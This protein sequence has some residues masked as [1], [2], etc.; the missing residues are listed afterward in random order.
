[1]RKRT[2]RIS[3]P[4]KKVSKKTTSIDNV[5]GEGTVVVTSMAAWDHTGGGQTTQK[6]AEALRGFGYNILFTSCAPTPTPELDGIEVVFLP[7]TEVDIPKD[8][9]G[10]VGMAY[11]HNGADIMHKAQAAGIPFLYHALDW[12]EGFDNPVEW[13]SDIEEEMWQEADYVSASARVL[14]KHLNEA[15]GQRDDALYIANTGDSNYLKREWVERPSEVSVVYC[16]SAFGEWHDWRVLFDTSAMRPDWTISVVGPSPD[17]LVDE[18]RMHGINYHPTV[19]HAEL[20]HYIEA[21]SV[22][23]IPFEMSK[24]CESVHPLKLHDYLMLGRPVVS[25]WM[26][27]VASF[28]YTFIPSPGEWPNAIEK[29]HNANVDKSVVDSCYRHNTWRDRAITLSNEVLLS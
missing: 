8:C 26:P 18:F 14:I 4:Q 21:A 1:M 16:G 29:A 11:N 25:S 17:Y 5:R 10:V 9:V 24:L 12:W 2:V 19:P 27:E 6:I 20:P 3:C 28:P 15:Y 22:G 7:G 23:V 13:D